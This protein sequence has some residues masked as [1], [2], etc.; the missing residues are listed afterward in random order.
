MGDAESVGGPQQRNRDTR[1]IEG[2]DR[3]QPA[4]SE[5]PEFAPNSR[6][7]H[8]HAQGITPDPNDLCARALALQ[9]F[10]EGLAIRAVRE[11]DFDEAQVVVAVRILVPGL[12]DFGDRQR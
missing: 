8:A 3:L 10:I 12:L 2:I 9:S 4:P 7:Q 1:K 5:C 11:P 6:S